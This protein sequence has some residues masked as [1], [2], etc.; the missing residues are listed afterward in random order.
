MMKNLFNQSIVLAII[1]TLGISG[2]S[3]AESKYRNQAKNRAPI[4]QIQGDSPDVLLK[5]GINQVVRFLRQSG[6]RNLSQISKFIDNKI[7]GYF[8]FKQMTLLAAGRHSRRMTQEQLNILSKNIRKTFV[9]SLAKNLVDY[10][11]T[12][13]KIKFLPPRRSRFGNEVTATAMITHPKGYPTRISFRFHPTKSG[14]KVYDLSANGQSAIMHYRGQIS[15]MKAGKTARRSPRP[16]RESRSQRR[17][18]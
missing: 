7:S 17:R 6:E 2:A 15:R 9:E 3:F 13:K 1:G 8:D 12:D 4:E 18:R 14:W 5:N 16:Y 10:A 11:Y